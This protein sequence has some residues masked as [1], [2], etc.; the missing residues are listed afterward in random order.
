M[1]GLEFMIA[2]VFRINV[3]LITQFLLHVVAVI[4]VL[5]PIEL[6]ESWPSWHAD[7]RQRLSAGPALGG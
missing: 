4:F 1:F 5:K 7:Q 2:L 3:K 6:V